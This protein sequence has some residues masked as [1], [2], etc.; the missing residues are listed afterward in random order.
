MINVRFN[1][2]K[3]P[4]LPERYK[5][6]VDRTNEK[7]ILKTYL[8]REF[9]NGNLSI[10]PG[11]TGGRVLDLG[12]GIGA[13]TSFLS[14]LF[15]GN[16]VVGIERSKQL[17]N[18]GERNVPTDANITLI[19]CCFEDFNKYNWDFILCS[20]VLQYIDT[21]LKEFLKK[22]WESLRPGGET[23]IILQEESGINQ[24]VK[25]ALPV[26]SNPDPHFLNW[27]VHNHVRKSLDE[28]GIHFTTNWFRSYFRA[29]NFKNPT[30]DDKNLLNF[31]LLG[32]FEPDNE[33]LVARLEE[34]NNLVTPDGFFPHDVGI[35][36]IRK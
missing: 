18:Y 21:D 30:L 6:Y 35:T 9:N 34:L 1:D 11:G 7:E 33:I 26:L 32:G 20:H 3:Y 16:D 27:F 13:L 12:C 8:M 4:I 31:I 2:N 5:A 15:T 10:R 17:L 36:R 19:N 14:E 23:W 28:L 29:P 25:T 22:I 24:F